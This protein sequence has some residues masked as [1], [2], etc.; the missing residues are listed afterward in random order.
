MDL[1]PKNNVLFGTVFIIK[2]NQYHQLSPISKFEAI[3]FTIDNLFIQYYNESGIPSLY[4][5]DKIKYKACMMKDENY[6]VFK[7][8]KLVKIIIN[9][10]VI[11]NKYI[12]NFSDDLTD[13]YIK[14][15]DKFNIYGNVENVKDVFCWGNVLEEDLKF[16]L[17]HK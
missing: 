15:T 4:V 12:L 6:Q 9:N 16:I 2:F 1:N 13:P 8:K 7:E 14:L 5:S 3:N 17:E 10:V 11:W